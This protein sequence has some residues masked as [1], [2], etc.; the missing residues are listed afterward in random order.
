MVGVARARFFESA[1]VILAKDCLSFP[2]RHFG[3]RANAWKAAERFLRT[4]LRDSAVIDLRSPSDSRECIAAGARGAHL[5]ENL[6]SVACDERREADA[7][8]RACRCGCA[9]WRRRHP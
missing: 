9:P 7:A 8:N 1:Q 6:L 4:A 5:R 2:S 3:S